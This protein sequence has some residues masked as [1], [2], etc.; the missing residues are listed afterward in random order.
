M[1]VWDLR[2][3][4]I[5]ICWLYLIPIDFW[6][7]VLII[8]IDTTT[9]SF[10]IS[11]FNRIHEFVPP[12]IALTPGFSNRPQGQEALQSSVVCG[13]WL[14]Y[15]KLDWLSPCFGIWYRITSSWSYLPTWS[16]PRNLFTLRS[17]LSFRNLRQFSFLQDAMKPEAL[18]ARFSNKMGEGQ[19]RDFFWTVVL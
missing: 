17:S 18:S 1:Y 6:H 14:H 3:L 4:M 16:H 8:T 10:S 7:M 19:I 11:T 15:P 12:L 2:R 5:S 13:F 9:G